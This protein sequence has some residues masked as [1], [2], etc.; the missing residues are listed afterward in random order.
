MEPEWKYENKFY[1]HEEEK[2]FS[3]LSVR[4]GGLT[5]LTFRVATVNWRRKDLWK[6]AFYLHLLA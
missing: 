1:V 4:N 6:M 5:S 2:K 3:K